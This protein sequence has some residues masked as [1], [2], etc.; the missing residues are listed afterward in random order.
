M[1]RVELPQFE[2]STAVNDALPLVIPKITE[3]SQYKNIIA[4]E[5]PDSDNLFELLKVSGQDDARE[6]WKGVRLII[7]KDA[8]AFPQDGEIVHV[9]Y[10]M[11]WVHNVK[12]TQQNKVSTVLIEKIQEMSKQRLLSPLQNATVSV[13]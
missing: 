6:I 4:F 10:D 11:V 13:T 12:L 7:H 2:P 1:N 8:Y 9:P 5:D 3:A